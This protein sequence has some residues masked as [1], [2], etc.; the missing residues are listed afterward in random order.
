MVN[1]NNSGQ[2]IGDGHRGGAVV[3]EYGRSPLI[4]EIVVYPLNRAELRTADAYDTFRSSQE[5]AAIDLAVRAR[6]SAYAARFRHTREMSWRMPELYSAALVDGRMTIDHF[7][8]VWRRMDRHSGVREEIEEARQLREG[9]VSTEAAAPGYPGTGF[10]AGAVA[11][12]GDEVED[13]VYEVGEDHRFPAAENGR[14]GFVDQAVDRELT[15]WLHAAALHPV[16]RT[17]GEATGPVGSISV[18]RLRETVDRAVT[19]AVEDLH[20]YRADIARGGDQ[21]YAVPF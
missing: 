18:H 6:G 7:D 4:E 20:R 17:V 3:G 14:C 8:T 2:R 10:V 13:D 19:R 11:G 5:T 15:D 12:D 21:S 16:T 1:R 9:L